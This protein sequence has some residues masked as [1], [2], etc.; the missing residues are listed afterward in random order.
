[1]EEREEES[2]SSV[3]GTVHA[4]TSEDTF[5]ELVLSFYLVE[6]RSFLFLSVSVPQPCLPYYY[7]SLSLPFPSTSAEIRDCAPLCLTLT[8]SFKHL[9]LFP[10]GVVGIEPRASGVLGKYSTNCALLA[11]P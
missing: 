8:R 4:W 3:Y 10:F 1:M 6:A 2:G 7:S 9:L 5:Q 11:V